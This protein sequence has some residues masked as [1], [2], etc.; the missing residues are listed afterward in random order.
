MGHPALNP[1]PSLAVL[2]SVTQKP[3]YQS[4][5]QVAHTCSGWWEPLTVKSLSVVS[6]SPSSPSFKTVFG[7]RRER[8]TRPLSLAPAHPLWL[9]AAR[10]CCTCALSTW[11]ML[12]EI[13]RR[14]HIFFIDLLDMAASGA[15]SGVPENSMSK[16][17]ARVTGIVS[18][19]FII[20][21]E[22]YR[23]N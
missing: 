20:N 4:S 8:R 23:I 18:L 22:F 11:W 1:L 5:V 19:I 9:V 2:S 16:H 3:H 17:C 12:L 21:S 14:A 7:E 10:C 13:L 15:L 6:G